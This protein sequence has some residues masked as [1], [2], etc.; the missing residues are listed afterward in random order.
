MAVIN[1]DRGSKD[2]PNNTE[3]NS[4]LIA[5]D[6]EIRNL[7][8]MLYN[9]G[10]RIKVYK[11]LFCPNVK[12][13][14]GAEHEIDCSL[15]RGTGFIDVDP[16]DTFAFIQGQSREYL[17][18][19]ENIGTQ[20]EEGVALASFIGGIDLT[21]YTRIELM[22]YTYLYVQLVQRQPSTN[23][24]R[25]KFSAHSVNK[26]IDQDGVEYFYGTDFN[27]DRNGDVE[28]LIVGAA[29]KPTDKYTYSIHYNTLVSYRALR[30][31]H[32]ERYGTEGKKRDYL[33]A[34]QYP[35]Q[36]LIKRLYLFDSNRKDSETDEKL[37]PN[38][39]FPKD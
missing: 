20:W 35:Q 37:D 26:V 12:S 13:I 11:T 32:C 39:I 14:D 18:N 36:W 29:K 31:L 1:N 22:D 10:V 4:K 28:W 19:P 21:Y 23:V 24:D 17:I 25:L 15:C 34:V 30:A 6:I 2:V 27:L 16:I 8:A 5:P 38:K 33:E 3:Y 9:Q 7:N